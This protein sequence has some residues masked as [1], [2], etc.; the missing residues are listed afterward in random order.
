MQLWDERHASEPALAKLC[1]IFGGK[2]RRDRASCPRPFGHFCLSTKPYLSNAYW[3][4]DLSRKYMKSTQ[5]E[6]K[7]SLPRIFAYCRHDA[8]SAKIDIHVSGHPST[9]TP[10]AKPRPRVV[11]A[12]ARL[13]RATQR[14]ATQRKTENVLP[15]PTPL[16]LAANT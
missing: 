4:T 11:R 3:F 16:P 8:H 10:T 15:L 9:P 13:H 2:H 1:V 14:N 12:L 7:M 5:D 6:S